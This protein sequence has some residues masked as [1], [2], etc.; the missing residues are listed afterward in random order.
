MYLC[1]AGVYKNDGTG[2]L[3]QCAKW[4]VSVHVIF[5]CTGSKEEQQEGVGTKIHL[6]HQT[7]VDPQ[8]STC[9]IFHNSSTRPISLLKSWSMNSPITGVF[10]LILSVNDPQQTH[11]EESSDLLDSLNPIKLIRQT[12]TYELHQQNVLILTRYRIWPANT[13]GQEPECTGWLVLSFV[14]AEVVQHGVFQS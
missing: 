9:P 8:H 3:I 13:I 6:Q 2:H 12:I 7:P 14:S 11:P 5:Q 4:C 10:A 1:L